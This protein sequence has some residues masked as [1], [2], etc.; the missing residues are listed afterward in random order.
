MAEEDRVEAVQADSGGWHWILVRDGSEVVRSTGSFDAATEAV[1]AGRATCTTRVTAGGAT[2]SERVDQTDWSKGLLGITG[3]LVVGVLAALGVSG[4]LL[5][6]MV[7][8]SADDVYVPLVVLLAAGGLLAAFVAWTSASSLRVKLFTS[9]VAVVVALMLIEIAEIGKESQETRERP[10]VAL[11]ISQLDSGG[12]EVSANAAGTSLRSGERMLLQVIQLARPLS[13]WNQ[14]RGV[15]TDA[16]DTVH[17]AGAYGIENVTVL[18]WA[19]V[20][21]DSRGEARSETQ[22]P[23]PAG[24]PPSTP[25]CALAQVVSRPGETVADRDIAWASVN[26][27]EWD[28]E[29]DLGDEREAESNEPAAEGG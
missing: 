8:N 26:G 24:T 7:R 4:D 14:L 6:R 11:R 25:V 2:A 29:V 17:G 19:E 23:L 3:A 18:S 22:V 20:G 21:P 12:L 28:A 1:E 10:S 27:V 5:A 16:L 15:C 9:V 13:S